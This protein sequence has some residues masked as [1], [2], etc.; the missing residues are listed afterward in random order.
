VNL[1]ELQRW[2][3]EALAD[4]LAR[5]FFD[6]AHAGDIELRTPEDVLGHRLAVVARYVIASLETSPHKGLGEDDHAAIL[7]AY[8]HLATGAVPHLWSEALWQ[9]I[10]SQRLPDHVISPRALP[11]PYT[12]HTWPTSR[13]AGKLGTWFAVLIIDT[14]KSIRVSEMWADADGDELVVELDVPYGKVWPDDFPE[15][16]NDEHEDSKVGS[17]LRMMALLSSPY[18]PRTRERMSRGARRELRRR[19][20]EVDPEDEVTFVLLRR[21]ADGRREKAETE[22]EVEWKH[23]WLVSGHLRAQ[24]YPSEQAHH[25]IWVAPY[26]KGPEDAPFLDHVYKVAR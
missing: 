7:T 9:Q 2:A 12:W 11:L 17:L 14:Q 24:W 18:I 26:M 21:V 15:H 10:W 13:G 16:E 1:D 22:T 25:L 20:S 19:G 4:P 6:R 23:R 3:D 5:R 8:I